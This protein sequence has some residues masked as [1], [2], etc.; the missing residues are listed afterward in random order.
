MWWSGVHL[1]GWGKN[2]G[3]PSF[4]TEE[5]VCI[6]SQHYEDH[7]LGFWTSGRISRPRRSSETGLFW[8][9]KRCETLLWV[10]ASQE[11]LQKPFSSVICYADS[12]LHVHLHLYFQLMLWGTLQRLYSVLYVKGSSS[13]KPS[14]AS[15]LEFQ[16]GKRVKGLKSQGP[17]SENSRRERKRQAMKAKDA[18]QKK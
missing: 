3:V 9:G 5:T 12:Q 11:F 1:D 6:H 7:H 2:N 17:E 8:D 16:A 18:K 13:P 10:K 14:D 15:V 4:S